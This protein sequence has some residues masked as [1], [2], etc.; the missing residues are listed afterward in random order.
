MHSPSD[1]VQITIVICCSV[2]I[3]LWMVRSTIH[4]LAIMKDESFTFRI[5]LMKGIEL[6]RGDHKPPSKTQ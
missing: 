1:E 5:T 6:Y 4:R 2:L 3:A